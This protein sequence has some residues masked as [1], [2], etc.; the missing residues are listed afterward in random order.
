M[1]NEP[2]AGEVEPEPTS[3]FLI[4]YSRGRKVGRLH[5]VGGCHCARTLDFLDFVYVDDD[6]PNEDMYTA[7]CASPGCW[8][9]GLTE[10]IITKAD[11]SSASSS[12]SSS[13]H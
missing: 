7:V 3:C 9:K 10:K 8:P 13:S 2:D 1:P 6:A 4:A 5:R 12:S 11:S